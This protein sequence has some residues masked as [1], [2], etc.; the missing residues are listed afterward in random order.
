MNVYGGSNTSSGE[1]A[2]NDN[3]SA[4][5]HKQILENRKA[6]DEEEEDQ[7]EFDTFFFKS[8]FGVD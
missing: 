3:R 7:V 4:A 6:G 2:V 1:G 8:V 5:A